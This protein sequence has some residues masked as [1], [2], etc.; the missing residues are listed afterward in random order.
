MYEA[1]TPALYVKS[2]GERPATAMLRLTAAAERVVVRLTGGC[3]L[4]AAKD[5]A[6]MQSLVSTAFTG[7][8]GGL[9]FGGT[10]MLLREDNSVLPGITELAPRIRDDNP[11]CVAMGV[12]PRTGGLSVTPA[13]LV[14]DDG[15]APWRTIVHPHQDVCLMVQDGVDEGSMWDSEWQECLRIIGDLRQ[16]AGWASVLF[17]WNGGKATER[18]LLAHAERGWPVLLVTGSGRTADF[19][20]AD[21]AFL[22]KYPSV[23]VAAAEAQ[24]IRAVLHNLGAVPALPPA[25][26]VICGVQA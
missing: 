1:V 2:R 11:G 25:P 13:G 12:V 21:K 6:P 14:I 18:E 8:R 7:F 19:Y 3:G 17:V 4:M 10:R 15:N 26:K 16:V 23:R 24:A 9:L 22:A 20:A 5:A